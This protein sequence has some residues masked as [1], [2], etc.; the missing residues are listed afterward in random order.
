MTNGM[1]GR[2]ALCRG[3]G[4]GG[5]RDGAR[6]SRCLANCPKWHLENIGGVA[7][8][9]TEDARLD[10]HPEN[11]EDEHTASFIDNKISYYLG[12]VN[13]EC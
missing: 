2:A 9:K 10:S 7:S 12:A 8:G 6:P 5:G 13:R 3:R 1:R 4:R 11:P